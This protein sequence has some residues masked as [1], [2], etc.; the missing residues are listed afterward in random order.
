MY[1]T[2][3]AFVVT[4]RFAPRN[5]FPLVKR[6]FGHLT[7]KGKQVSV[8]ICF[9]FVVK[10]RFRHL[11]TKGKQV[12]DLEPENLSPLRRQMAISL[13]ICF[14]FVVKWRNRRLTTKGK[15]LNPDRSLVPPILLMRAHTKSS[16]RRPAAHGAAHFD[17]FG[18]V[19]AAASALRMLG[20]RTLGFLVSRFR[21]LGFRG[22]RV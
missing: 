3:N 12:S 1:L 10:R 6:R 7:T 13:N 4:R 9:P 14:P 11:T 8:Q 17:P 5:L 22:L 16:P 21:G 15:P 20:F 19:A 2:L 18:A